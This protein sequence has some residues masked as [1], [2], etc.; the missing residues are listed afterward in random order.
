METKRI[1]VEGF[2][3]VVAKGESGAYV[4]I[5]PGLPGVV[6]QVDDVSDAKA[7][8]RRL[9]GAHLRAIAAARS[10]RD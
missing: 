5:V 6:G 10:A 7:E 1:H 3:A 9:I 4:I 2:E 8:I